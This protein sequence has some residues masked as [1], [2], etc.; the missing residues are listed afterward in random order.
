MKFYSNCKDKM[1][2]HGFSQKKM[3]EHGQYQVLLV[4]E[5]LL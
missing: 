5:L 1:F 3:F 4:L 2:D